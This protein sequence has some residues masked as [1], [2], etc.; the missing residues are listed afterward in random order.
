MWQMSGLKAWVLALESA[1][2]AIDLGVPT[3]ICG[4]SFPK[5]FGNSKEALLWGRAHARD[6]DLVVFHSTWSIID[7]R[8]AM[9]CHRLGVPYL[10]ISHGSLDPFDLKKKRVWKLLLGPLVVR[11]YLSHSQGV[12]CST[13]MEA[14]RLIKY[15]ARPS[16]IVMPWSVDVEAATS[17]RAETRAAYGLNEDEFV[18]L[19]LGRID[20][21][22]GFPI[23]IPAFRRLLQSGIRGRIVIAGPD[24]K[25]YLA[26]VQGMVDEEGVGDKTM[27]LPPVTG[28]AKS[29]LMQAADCFVLPSLNENFGN[30]VVEA[31]QNGLPVVISD[32]VYIAEQVSR[33]KGGIVCRY[34]EDDLFDGLCRIAREDETRKA[35]AERA[36]RFGETLRPISMGK[37]YV[38]VLEA[39]VRGFKNT[40]ASSA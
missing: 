3:T 13:E 20:Y 6:F 27:F 40:L 18:L 28:G 35:M 9:E 15:G 12:V 10:V 4:R 2:K 30:T 7:I 24:S 5:R 22:K 17:T 32:N 8:L 19:S 26:K 25:G 38:S 23:L 16:M 31:M 36:R 33:A 37:K 21:K 34:H 11:P 29:S 1:G 14:A 39:V